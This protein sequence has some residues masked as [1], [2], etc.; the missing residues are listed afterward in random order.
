MELS[1]NPLWLAVTL[2]L[3]LWGC[4]S[5]ATHRA[6]TGELEIVQ[7]DN[8]RLSQLNQQLKDDQWSRSDQLSAL[9]RRI[10]A[11]ELENSA[12]DSDSELLSQ[13]NVELSEDVDRL[14]RRNQD[15]LDS[16]ETNGMELKTRDDEM[17]LLRAQLQKMEELKAKVRA[18]EFAAEA[19]SKD[20]IYLRSKA[21]RREE[22]RRKNSNLIQE[23]LSRLNEA[24]PEDDRQEGF[25]VIR[26]ED[27]LKIRL[28]EAMLFDAEQVQLS[29]KGRTLLSRM[30]SVFNQSSGFA[31]EI[32][33]HTD[34]VPIGPRLIELYPTNWELSAARSGRVTRYIQNNTTVDQNHLSLIGLADSKPIADND[35]P[36]GRAMNRRIDIVFLPIQPGDQT[37]MEDA[38]RSPTGSEVKP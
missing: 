30:K 6:A 14:K 33:G 21:R 31:I 17:T 35:T 8:L 32:Q 34:N 16:L 11:L 15:L 24:I 9:N 3:T 27:H 4:V 20:I 7:A 26:T 13:Q 29:L 10:A 38:T 5:Q 23:I 1:S 22:I 36:Q 19:L 12:Q 25:T 2:S 37:P 28:G 18:F